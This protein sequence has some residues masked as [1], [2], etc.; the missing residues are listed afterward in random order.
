VRDFNLGIIG[1]CLTHQPG[2]PKSELYH[3]RLKRILA[4]KGLVNL[5][6]HIVRQFSEDHASRLAALA[7]EHPLDGVLIHV[8]NYYL[9]KSVIITKSVTNEEFRYH[10]HPFLFKPWE[11]GWAKM[12]KSNFSGQ[13]VI[14][15]RP[16]TLKDYSQSEE[17]NSYRSVSNVQP[18]KGG[19]DP[20]ARR[21]LGFSIRDMFFAAGVLARLDSW[22][23]RDELRML[24]EAMGKCRRLGLPLIV[25]GPARRPSHYWLDR[26]CRKLDKRLIHDLQKHFVPYCSV[27]ELADAEGN[28]LYLADEWHFSI[29]GHRHV[30]ERLGRITSNWLN[31]LGSKK[32]VCYD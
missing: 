5:K 11:T 18:R 28:S 8:R 20:G 3:R 10:L 9:N 25:L 14:L 29:H 22:A 27:P 15:R 32:T 21:F 1:G 26:N 16:N 4:E 19:T 7:K 13:P 23:V 24:H 30:A 6:I 2:I 12:L 31:M 17:S